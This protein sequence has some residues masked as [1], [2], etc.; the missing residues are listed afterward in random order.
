MRRS[1]IIIWGILLLIKQGAIIGSEKSQKY[2]LEVLVP[3]G[4][5]Q[6][7]VA[8]PVM[9]SEELDIYSGGIEIMIWR[10]DLTEERNTGVIVNPEDFSL[11]HGGEIAKA[12]VSKDPKWK[13]LIMDKLLTYQE[14]QGFKDDGQRAI[15]T[16][17]FKLKEDWN[18]P[19][20]INVV[21]PTGDDKDWKEKLEKSYDDILQVLIDSEDAKLTDVTLPVDIVLK[22]K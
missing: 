17:T 1:I 20:I 9:S 2:F 7:F 4:S 16:P 12:L 19:W 10:G 14:D 18:I 11:S 13:N 21:A 6:F 15:L 3:K 22:K 8:K 5:N